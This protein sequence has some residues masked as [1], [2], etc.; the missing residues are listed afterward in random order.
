MLTLKTTL[1]LLGSVALAA[2]AGGC[3]VAD[4]S[5]VAHDGATIGVEEVHEGGTFALP[6]PAGS[7]ERTT[8]TA[9]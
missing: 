5:A 2:A 4:V 7:C 8:L 1:G 9:R 6:I 3:R